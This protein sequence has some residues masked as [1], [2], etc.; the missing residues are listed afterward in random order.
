MDPLGGLGSPLP[1][2]RPWKLGFRVQGLGLGMLGLSWDNGKERGNYYSLL[3]L[4]RDNGEN[5]SSYSMLGLC[6]H[7]GKKME[8]TI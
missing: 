2:K 4:Y 5:G 3:G 6:W 1:S 8:T 7:N